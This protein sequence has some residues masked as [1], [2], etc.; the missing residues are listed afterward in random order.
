[1]SIDHGTLRNVIRRPSEERFDLVFARRTGLVAK[2]SVDCM[3]KAGS[4]EVVP[5][6]FEQREREPHQCDGSCWF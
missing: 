4:R 6:L 5:I 1:M 3:L 2:S